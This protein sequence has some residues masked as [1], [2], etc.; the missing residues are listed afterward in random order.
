[1]VECLEADPAL[2]G[3]VPVLVVH[4]CEAANRFRSRPTCCGSRC[5]RLPPAVRSPR[6]GRV[7]RPDGRRRPQPGRYSREDDGTRE[8]IAPLAD[9][10]RSCRSTRS[11]ARL[12]SPAP[13][14]RFCYEPL[15]EVRRLVFIA[16][17]HRGSPLAGGLIR[18]LGSADLRSCERVPRGTRGGSWLRTNPNYFFR[19]SGR[20]TPTRWRAGRRTFAPVG[21][22]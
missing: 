16:T 8:R 9:G 18:K 14:T 22:F 15:P 7:L 17:P 1:M 11:P 10:L 13:T 6:H 2:T 12:G 4:L 21:P 19:P 20:Q 5:G 3:K